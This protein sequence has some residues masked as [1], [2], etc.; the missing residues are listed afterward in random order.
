MGAEVPR[1]TGLAQDSQ[2][3]GVP[4]VLRE[5]ELHVWH[6]ELSP[7]EEPP[8]L[9]SLLSPDEKQRANRFKFEIDRHRF[10]I[11]RTRLRQLLAKYLRIEPG[12]IRFTY[13]R[14]GKPQ[15]A[16]DFRSE[17]SFNLAHSKDLAAFAFTLGRRVGIDVEFVRNDIDADRIA[18]RFFSE[19]EQQ[20]LAQLSGDR[21]YEG[22]FNCWARK[23]AYVKAMGSGLFSLPLRDFDVTLKPG[24]PARLVAVR[25]S[26]EQASNWSMGALTLH[27][28][29]AA[30]VVFEGTGLELRTLQATA[31]VL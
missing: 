8:R 20:S 26:E 1:V 10:T 22:F 7:S 16:G 30:A 24:E 14:S 15:L 28:E 13:S 19:F 4:F 29:Y 3:T 9:Q 23:E 2:S 6:T 18:R 31:G 5:N 11:A 17:I 27:P 12:D 21:K 25:S